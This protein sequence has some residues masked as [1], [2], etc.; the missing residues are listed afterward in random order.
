MTRLAVLADIH[1]NLPALEAVIADLGRRGVDAVV[2]LGD[3][4]S[5]PLWPAETL[6]LL[7]RLDWPTAR[8]NHDRTVALGSSA[9][10][11]ASDRFARERLSEDDCAWLGSRPALLRL[12]DG[13]VALHARPDDD[14]AYL[15]E[16]QHGRHLVRASAETVARRLGDLTASVVLTAHSHIGGMLRLPDGRWVLNPGSV[17]CPA[18]DDDSTNPPHISESG[19]SLARYAI[20]ETTDSTPM[21]EM[22]ALPYPHEAAAARADDAGRPD[23]AHALRTGFTPQVAA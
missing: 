9:G 13:I 23:W 1:G 21:I 2:N 3:C 11:G 15:L 10:L 4:V 20:L 18:Y 14:A 12:D 16:D 8:G 22:F 19:S 5:G 7:R 6:A 17:G